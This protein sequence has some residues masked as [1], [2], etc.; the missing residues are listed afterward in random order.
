MKKNSTFRILARDRLMSND[1]WMTG[2]NNNDLIVGPSGAG[3]TRGYVKPNILQCNESMIVADTKGSLIGEVGPVLEQNGYRLLHLNFKDLG[4][5]CG[6][7]PLDYVHYD[8]RRRKYSEQN[9]MTVANALVPVKTQK[10]P[11]WEEAARMYLASLIAYVLECLPK[12]E[13]SLKYAVDLLCEMPTG[14]FRKLLNERKAVRPDSFAVQTFSLYQDNCKAE[15]MEASI[16]GILGEKLN[17]LNFDG[18]IKMF[19]RKDRIDFR[20]VGREKTAVFLTISDTDRSMDRLISLFYTQALHE[21][22]T[23]AD[24]DYPD[25]RLP[26]PVRFIL[27]DFATNACIPDFHNITSVIRSREISVSIIL[28]SITQLNALYGPANAEAI[29]NNCDNCLYLGGQD[30]ETARFMSVKANKTVDTILNMPLTD[31]W[32]FTRGQRPQKI[33]KFDLRS[34]E[35]YHL[36]PEAQAACPGAARRQPD[37]STRTDAAET[38]NISNHSERSL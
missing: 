28:Q 32:L 16:I 22:C 14:N 38:E 24:A 3:K 20:A 31:A 35:K 4:S 15:K 33:E 27:D 29:I 17:G 1:T 21:L 9:I 13:H 26:V 2:L 7:N 34:H 18:A 5:A 19:S 30:V 36:L 6:Y 25:H 37:T 11:F 10:D 12:R 8:G 23:S